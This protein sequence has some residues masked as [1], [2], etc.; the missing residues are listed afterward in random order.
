MSHVVLLGDSIFDNASYVPGGPPVIQQLASALPAGWRATLLAID[1]AT[2]ESAHAQ[3]FRLPV[4]AT[5]LVI[6]AG[7]SAS[8]R[9]P[10][11]RSSNEYVTEAARSNA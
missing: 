8:S 6:S 5:H 9:V 11:T 2:I 4:D 7:G 10:G 3:F 1:G